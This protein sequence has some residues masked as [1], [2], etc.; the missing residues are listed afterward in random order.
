MNTLPKYEQR[1]IMN[2][3]MKYINCFLY[4]EYK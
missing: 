4:K 3:V 2:T 1:I